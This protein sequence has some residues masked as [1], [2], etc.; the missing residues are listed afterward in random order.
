MK[1]KCSNAAARD[2]KSVIV[3]F[4]TDGTHKIVWRWNEDR[5]IQEGER[6][7]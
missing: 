5:W 3:R 1:M 6:N 2:N 7:E 4:D